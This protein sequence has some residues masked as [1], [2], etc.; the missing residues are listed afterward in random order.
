VDFQGNMSSSTQE[1]YAIRMT[2]AF[3]QL[4]FTIPTN[5]YD[6][7]TLETEMTPRSQ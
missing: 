3:A 7:Y 6:Y 4:E 1:H 5:A 2:L